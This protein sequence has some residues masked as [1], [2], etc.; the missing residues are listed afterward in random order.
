MTQQIDLT[1]TEE[2]IKSVIKRMEDVTEYLHLGLGKVY[3]KNDREVVEKVRTV[4]SLDR[5][6]MLTKEISVAVV[7]QRDVSMFIEASQF[8][9]EDFANL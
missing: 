5:V 1:G 3:D 4:L 2:I 8:I 6:L 7:M 9:D